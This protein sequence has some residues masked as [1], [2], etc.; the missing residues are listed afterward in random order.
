MKFFII[1]FTLIFLAGCSFDN[2]SGIWKNNNNITKKDKDIFS[3]FKT[4]SSSKKSFNKIIPLN[5]NFNFNIKNNQSSFKWTDIFYSPSNNFDNFNYGNSNQLIFKSKKISKK[6]VSQYILFENNN[7][8]TSDDNG[9]LIIFSLDKNKDIEKFNFYKKK[10]KKFKIKLNI[11]VENNIIYVSDNLGFLYAFDYF[12]KKV[13][14]AKNYKVPFRSNL[15][16]YKNKIIAASQNN[17][18]Y[19]FNKKTGETI[20][21]IP[22]EETKVK[23]KFINNISISEDFSLYLNTYGSLYSIRNENSKI[24]WFINLNQSLDLNPSNLFQG[25]QIVSSKNKIII[26][27]NDFTYIIDNKTGSILHKKNFS[28]MIKPLL[29]NNYLFIVTKNN[30]LISLNLENGSIIYSYEINEQVSDFLKS[31]KKKVSFKSMAMSNKSILIFLEN[32]FVLQY[33]VNG[34]LEDI[35]KLPTKIKSDPIFI[36]KSLIYLDKKNKI[37]LLN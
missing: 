6:K 26:S 15:K 22:T 36:D 25:S 35:K 17:D 27:T 16:I 30:F 10:Y 11:I 24:N 18:L 5:E 20:S 28:S 31:K 4:L 32:A 34:R 3:D 23:N 13:I 19:F 29:I 1:F 8:I 21:L 33:N 14:W 12:K 9:N 37:S 2:K 7:I